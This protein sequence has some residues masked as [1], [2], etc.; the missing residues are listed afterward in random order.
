MSSESEILIRIR[1]LA[2]RLQKKEVLKG[3]DYDIRKGDIVVILGRSGCGKSV[4]LK[5]IA[6]LFKPDAGSISVGP[7]EISRVDTLD[8]LR[9]GVKISMLFQNSALFDSLTIREN[10]GF[11]LDRYS[12]IPETAR[13][14]KVREKLALVDLKNVESLKPFQLSGGMQKRV[15]LARALMMEPDIMLYD[16]PTTG[17]DPITADAINNMILELNRKFSMTSIVVT[18]DLQSAFKVADRLAMLHDGVIVFDGT[19]EEIQKSDHPHVRMFLSGSD[20]LEE[21]YM[22]QR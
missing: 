20:H 9:L 4:L 17:L 8:F 1:G 16:E 22:T 6:G 18:H 2:K 5:H 15:A 19:A 14:E 12:P 11:Y 13:D 7:V 21:A 10:V 3:V